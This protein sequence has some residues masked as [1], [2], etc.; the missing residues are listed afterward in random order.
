MNWHAE[1]SARLHAALAGLVPDPAPF[2]AMLRT[3]GDPKFGDYQANCAM[4]LGKALSRPPRDVAADIVAKLDV[5]DLC[6]PP[7]IAG[8]GFINLRLRA[9]RLIAET[10]KLVTDDRLGVPVVAN[11]RTYVVDYSSPNVAKPMHVGHLR[12]T[13]I[14][15]ALDNVLRFLG[16]RVISDNHIGDWGTQFGMILYG[17]KHFRDDAAYAAEPVKELARLYRLVNQLCDYHQL[18]ADLPDLDAAVAR[19]ETEAALAKQAA[20]DKPGDK[21]LAKQAKKLEADLAAAKSAAN[22]ARKKRQAVDDN[23]ELAALAKAHPQIVELSRKETAK[24]HAGD[25]ENV[26]LWNQF[27]PQCLAALQGMYQRFGVTFDLTLGESFYNPLLAG[28]V[29]DLVTRGLATES[30]G[31]MC[32][33]VAGNAAPFIIRKADGAFT[34]ATTDLATIQHRVHELHADVIL[35]VVDARQSEHFQLLFATAKQIGYADTEF[36]HVSFGT[37]LGD[38]RKP[39]K[40]R[41]G[42]TVGLESLLDEAVRHARAIVDE[43]DDG[44]PNGPELDESQRAA[45][46]EIVGIGGIIYADLHH[47]RESDYV[48]NWEKMLAKTGDTATYIQYAYARV[49]GIFAQGQI[50]VDRLR[51]QPADIRLDAPAER[52]L[53]RQLHRFA[54]AVNDVVGD[55]RPNLLTQYLFETANVFATF[56]EQC[57]VLKEPDPALRTSRLLLCDLTSRVLKQGLALLGIGVAEKM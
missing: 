41:A 20:T 38:D 18:G 44:K 54:E 48:F 13:V 35:Y 26:A 46:A 24:L 14:G 29:D 17:Y 8:P 47:N 3:A 5:A 23:A 49:R 45:I 4:P 7:E 31:A 19:L 43:N 1:L 10:N 39:F 11:P 51:S 56:Y 55:D 33:F 36:R 21:E 37:I 22:S 40:T 27:I 52:Q 30:D 53:A 32:V 34:Y 6:E 2:A 28:V 16:H 9:D 42:D 50:A 25:A 12:S 15:H 57:P